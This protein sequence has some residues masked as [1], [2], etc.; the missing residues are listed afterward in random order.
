MILNLWALQN[1]TVR[2]F[3][4]NFDETNFLGMIISTKQWPTW[5]RRNEF[6][7]FKQAQANF[8]SSKT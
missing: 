7:A 3:P 8:V 4:I 6:W 5:I 2:I 1:K